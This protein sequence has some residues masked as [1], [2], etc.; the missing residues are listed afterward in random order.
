VTKDKQPTVSNRRSIILDTDDDDPMLSAINLV[1]VF[2]VVVGVLLIAVIENPLRPS[3]DENVTIIRDEGKPNMEIIV[4][5]GQQ[6]TKFQSVGGSIE[7]DGEM[8]GTAY[9]LRDGS[10]VYVPASRQQ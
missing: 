2:L 5:D 3:I 1:D 9:R 10:L 6:V 4:K 7:G 8:A